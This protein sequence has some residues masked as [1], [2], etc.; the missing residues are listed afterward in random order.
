MTGPEHF[1]EAQRLIAMARDGH[2]WADLYSHYGANQGVLIV[3]D[4]Q[5][6]ATLALAAATALGT[7]AAE[8]WAAVAGTK[9]SAGQAPE[10]PSLT[11]EPA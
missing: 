1:L 11:S 4:A 5:V 10:P 3:A 8:A 2:R 6:H 7:S 9:P